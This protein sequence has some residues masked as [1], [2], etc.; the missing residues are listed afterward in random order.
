[1]LEEVRSRDV[2]EGKFGD[3]QF[4]RLLR[5]LRELSQVYGVVHGRLYFHAAWKM[6]RQWQGWTGL[7][8][9]REVMLNIRL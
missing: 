1:M 3:L 8:V 4:L 5:S 2:S 7:G 9:D 6:V